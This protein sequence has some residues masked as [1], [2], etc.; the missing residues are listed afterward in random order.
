MKFKYGELTIEAEIIGEFKINEKEYVVCSY[1]DSMENYKI[2]IVEIVRKGNDVEVKD[3][4]DDEIDFVLKKYK[5]IE[6][7]LLG[8]E[9]IE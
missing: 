3:I 7:H 1:A 6:E 5:E 9:Q 8:G 4:P 2:G